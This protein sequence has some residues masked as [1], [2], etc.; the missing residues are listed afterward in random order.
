MA[1]FITDQEYN[2]GRADVRDFIMFV[3]EPLAQGGTNKS[4][5]PSEYI[6]VALAS[7]I[8]IT[9]KMYAERKQWNPGK[10]T[11]HC[12]YHTDE[13]GEKYIHKK[14]EFENTLN[15]EQEARLVF[16]GTKCPVS[17]M[18]N[19]KMVTEGFTK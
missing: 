8:G 6:L 13:H 17:K 18:L 16:I 12:D 10:I 9:M 19:L 3:D 14:I 4:P 2:K 15:E 7:C 11:V 1:K 5:T